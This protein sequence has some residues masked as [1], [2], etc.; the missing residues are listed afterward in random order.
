MSNTEIENKD[1]R[2]AKTRQLLGM[3]G[4]SS[5]ETSLWKIRLQ[6][7]KPITWIPL[8]WGV[9]CGAASSGN[10]TWSLE[11]VLKAATC[12]LLSGPL[13]TGYTQTLND[14]YDREIDAINE[15]YRPIP[16]GAISIPQVVGQILV[17]LAAGLGISYL[18]DRW[19]GH[20]F[21]IMLCLT[22]F[23]SFIAYIYSAP[24]LKLKQNG[25]L[26]NYALG[27]SYIALPWWAGH[28][29]FGQLNGT[30][31]ILTLIYSLAG[32]GIAVVND[33]KSVE[34][35][36]KLGLKS[37]P[38]MFGITT[39]AWICVIM[40]D[41]FQAGIAGYLI[42]IHQNLYAAILLLLIIPQITFQDM[43]FLRDPLKNDVKYQASAQPF[44]V[45]GMLVTGLALGQGI[46]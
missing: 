41:V 34:G 38:V 17:L 24:P 6:L 4:A 15:P 28:A 44:L 35:D 33:F 30:I 26:G 40:I 45:L 32:L 7:M 16:S 39:A 29:L 18:L 37:L 42:S 12:M 10:Y 9:V 3:K 14:F 25:W 27:A 22:L 2:G 11:D 13:M 1:E 46:L 31:M 8:I 36:E 19:A 5:A 23:G 43:Y 20:D 21:P